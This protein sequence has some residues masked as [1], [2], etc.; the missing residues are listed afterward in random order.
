MP[1]F[2]RQSGQIGLLGG[3]KLPQLQQGIAAVVVGG[4][5]RRFLIGCDG[6]PVGTSPIP[7]V[8]APDWIV[9]G[10]GGPLK[11][12]LLISLHRLQISLLCCLQVLRHKQLSSHHQRH[13]QPGADSG[14]QGER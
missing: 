12:P 8:A 10:A 4:G 14:Q 2:E 9:E 1:G 3:R 11:I 6:L 13:H 5:A 7:G